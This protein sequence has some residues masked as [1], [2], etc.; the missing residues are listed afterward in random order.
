MAKKKAFSPFVLLSGLDDGGDVTVIG[1]GTGQSTT[2]VFACTFEQWMTLFAS[3]FN[4]DGTTDFNDYHDWFFATFGE[5]AE[6]LWP[7][8]NPGEP[9]NSFT[10]PASME[11]PEAVDPVAE[12]LD[13]GV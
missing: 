8:F 2:N 9:G 6:D 4:G 12:M 5:E 7:I 11:D 13:P 10:E 1:G 3:D